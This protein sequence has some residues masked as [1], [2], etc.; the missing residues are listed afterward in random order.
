MADGSDPALRVVAGCL[1][2]VALEGGA[3]TDWRLGDTGPEVTLVSETAVGNEHHF[4]FRAEAAGAAA[5][6]VELR[7][8]SGDA[9]RIVV[10]RTVVVRIAPEHRPD[11]STTDLGCSGEA[12]T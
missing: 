9:E 11:A 6:G 3:G 12:G 8:E 1:F 4:R 7:F 5:G 2:E 10:A